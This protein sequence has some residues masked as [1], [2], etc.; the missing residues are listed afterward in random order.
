[1]VN[2]RL[3]LL[4]LVS[5]AILLLALTR[6]VI[7]QQLVTAAPPPAPVEL[8]SEPMILRFQEEIRANPENGDAYAQLG[9][10]FLQRVR[11][12]GDASLYTQAEQAFDGALRY[13]PEQ[14]DALVGQ[15]MLALARH[16]F[17]AALQ[18]GNQARA[19]NPYRAYTVGILV[20]ALVELGRYEEA[21]AQAQVM[22]D[23]RPD[24]ASYSRVSYLRELHGDSA[25][26]IA[27]MEMAVAAGVPTAEG[28]LWTQTQLG[29][30][31]FN[32]G[33]LDTAEATYQQALAWRPDYIY[34]QAG[35]ARIT[36]ARGNDAEAIAAYQAIVERMPLPE[37]V[38]PLGNLY[39][40]TGQTA[41]AERQ[42]DLVRAIQQL[43][44]AAGMDVDMELALFDADQGA[45]PAATLEKATAAYA[46]RPSIY[47]AD[48]LAWS[49]Y[50]NGQ[51]A[52]AWRYSQEALRL[53]TRDALLHYHAG[54][55]AYA[56]EDWPAARY[57]LQEALT[58]NPYFSI[59][60]AS[61]AAALLK[62][63]AAHP[64]Q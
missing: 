40:V 29:H 19:L 56:Q 62:E 60:Y 12:T 15:G 46:R 1:M 50:A 37:F 23:M 33:D 64:D 59:R 43:N 16:D 4:F 5:L 31:Y 25:G 22:V 13:D 30:L 55:I 39:E 41:E 9:L 61:Q 32:R 7:R 28:T 34:A 47:A 42:Y 49:L 36:A 11:E 38:I 27:A 57:H 3:K 17:E 45:D 63:M 44:A 58:I 24:L 21:L 54:Q 14:V 18:W 26:A 6:H 48:V 51:F 2:K 20:D 35:L 53:G 10:A 8:S 52:E